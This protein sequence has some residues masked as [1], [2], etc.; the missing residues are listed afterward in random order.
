V[1]LK[2]RMLIGECNMNGKHNGYAPR[3]KTEIQYLKVKKTL[4]MDGDTIVT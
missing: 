4:E 1:D 3:Q 2:G